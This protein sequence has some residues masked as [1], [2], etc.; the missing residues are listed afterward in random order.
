M[1]F[2]FAFAVIY[3]A[4]FHPK[5]LFLS[6]F[7]LTPISFN[8][9]EW[10][11]NFGLFIPTEPILFGL[12]LLVLW[13]SLIE[14][15]FPKYL[16]QNIISYSIA[17]FLL[18]MLYTSI[19][20]VSPMVSFKS[21][22]SK[23]WFVIPILAI[24]AK[25]FTEKKNIKIAI[26]G[27]LLGITIAI[28]YTIIHH[29][30]LNFGEREAYW[31]MSPLF[32]D[33]T[34]YGAMV[35]FCTP[36]LFGLL[37]S[38]KHTPQITIIL[39]SMLVINLIGLYFSFTRAAWL[40]IFVAFGVW[41]IIK[42]KIRF[43]WLALFAII[44]GTIIALN[45]KDVSYT[46]SKNKKE[47]KTEVFSE[48][49]SSAANISSDASNLERLNRW[50]CAIAMFERKPWTGFGPGTYAFEYA[51]FQLSENKTIITTNFG[52]VGNAHSEYLLVLSEMGIFGLLFFLFFVGAIFYKG[53]TLYLKLEE[54]EIKTIIL[55]CVL[56]LVT[57]FFHGLMNNYLD[58]D[59]ACVPIFG[60]CAMFIAI[61]HVNMRKLENKKF[62]TS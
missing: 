11:D 37:F 51:P 38:K 34:I 45:W 17:L 54:K 35:A 10:V 46:L 16:L 52:N 30:M 6:L 36:L 8:I 14:E 13:K 43:S 20:S 48:R 50:D 5:Q 31:V 47:S 57:Y 32:K 33:H 61:E 15:T 56:S 1:L 39:I 59:K 2:P 41:V 22:L 3:I 12:M 29:A 19:T 24:G 49:L 40:S 42:L 58:T 62:K 7:F 60:I 55:A 27:Y 28:I 18:V 53:I 21:L 9:D 23:L 26:W 25:T 44:M 4:L